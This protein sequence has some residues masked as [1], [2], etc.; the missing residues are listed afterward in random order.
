MAY[1]NLGIT[2]ERLGRLKE[3]KEILKKAMTLDSNN[4]KTVIA[5]GEL[6]LKLNDH[7]NGLSLISQAQGVIEFNQK[8][9]KII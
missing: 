5:Y 8:D 1:S 2:L 6:L 4:K 7:N 3:A 9:F